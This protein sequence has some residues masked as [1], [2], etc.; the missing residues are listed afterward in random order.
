[1]SDFK[2][3]GKPISS[4][5]DIRRQLERM[6]DG[7]KVQVSIIRMTTVGPQVSDVPVAIRVPALR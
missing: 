5:E 1:V 6:T 4:V 7:T 2:L 3:N